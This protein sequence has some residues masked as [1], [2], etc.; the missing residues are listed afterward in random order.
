MFYLNSN[1]SLNLSQAAYTSSDPIKKAIFETKVAPRGK[2][3]YMS[4][5]DGVKA[6]QKVSIY[7]IY[8]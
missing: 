2:P 6:M 4:I 7:L 5:E 1:D 3:N 8:L